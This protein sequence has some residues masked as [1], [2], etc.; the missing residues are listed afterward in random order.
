MYIYIYIN[1]C[2]II[3]LSA[4]KKSEE[5]PVPAHSKKSTGKMAILQHR[6]APLAVR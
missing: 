4:N 1:I 2:K 3:Y 5:I 6:I